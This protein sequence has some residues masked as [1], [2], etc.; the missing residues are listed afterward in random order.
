M[1]SASPQPRAGIARISPHMLAGDG[2]GLAPVA[3]NLAS[4]ES[5]WGPG[6]PAL[7]AARAAV[8]GSER[9]DEA[10][11]AR[12]GRGIA[13]RFGLDAT[14]IVV[15]HGSDDLL[16]RLARAYLEPGSE[17]VRS[18]NGYLKVPNYAHANDAVAVA[19]ADVEFR[20]SV[21]NLLAA[22]TEKTRAAYLANPDNPSGSWLTGA[23]VRRLHAGLP[24][25]VL[26][27]LDCAY[28][29]YVDAPDYEPAERLVE[30]AGNVVMTRTFSKVFGLAGL[31]LGWLYAPPGIAGVVARIG[32]TFPVSGP[33]VSAALAA[34]GDGAHTRMVFAANAA[35]RH[36]LTVRLGEL[37]LV[38]Y[39]S[40]GNFVLAGFPDPRRSAAEAAAMLRRHGVAVRR[41]ASPAYDGA[42][43]ITLG[44]PHEVEAACRLIA[45]FLKGGQ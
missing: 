24:R 37:G 43:R 16:A 41:F 8:T 10:A 33:A 34:L 44:L 17:L 1:N 9:Y 36:K 19:A 29:E 11:A 7:A 42:L 28:A 39:P 21:D 38:A 15:G 22:V 26:L 45:A 27:V 4:N 12:L 20:A 6:L 3:I 25:H 40:Q 23:E 32:L 30:E 13:G 14:R 31:R 2:A 35:E 5:V 18:A